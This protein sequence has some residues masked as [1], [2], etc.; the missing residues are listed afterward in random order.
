MSKP[1]SP[2]KIVFPDI[3]GSALEN[4]SIY[5]GTAGLDPVVEV[6]RITVYWDRALTLPASQPIATKGG[7]PVNGGVISRLYTNASDFSMTILDK[8]GASVQTDL[9][10]GLDSSESYTSPGPGAVSR[11]I[12]D[13][14]GDIVAVKDFG[15]VGDG[16]T[17][18][19]TAFQNALIQASGNVLLINEGT[20]NITS[21]LKAENVHIL[22]DKATITGTGSFR[23]VILNDVI[24]Y[25]IFKVPFNISLIGDR[26]DQDTGNLY[27]DP[28]LGDDANDGTLGNPVA[29]LS[30][31][32]VVLDALIALGGNTDINVVVRDGRVEVSSQVNLSASQST[33]KVTIKSNSGETPVFTGPIQWFFRDGSGTATNNGSTDVYSLFCVD[34]E[35]KFVPPTTTGFGDN[36]ALNRNQ[37]LAITEAANVCTLQVDTSV[38]GLINSSSNLTR[39]RL[40]VTQSFTSSI[41]HGISLAGVNMTYTKPASQSQIYYDGFNFGIESGFAPYFIEGLNAASLKTPENWCNNGTTLSLPDY[42]NIFLAPTEL[43][44]PIIVSADRYTFDGIVFKFHQPV[45][46]TV[47]DNYT[48]TPN[49][50]NSML[51]YT[52]ADCFFQNCSIQYVEGAG[53]HSS[54]NNMMILDNK[55]NFWVGHAC[56]FNGLDTNPESVTGCDMLRNEGRYWGVNNAGCRFLHGASAD[57]EIHDNIAF[58]GPTSALFV[59]AD[60]TTSI[61]IQCFRNVFY[62]LGMPEYEPSERFQVADS[63]GYYYNGVN[64][65]CDHQCHQNVVFNVTGYAGTRGYY[66]DNQGID[67][68]YQKNLGFNVAGRVF[69]NRNVSGLTDGNNYEENIFYGT[70]RVE[71]NT[72][73]TFTNN[74]LVGRNGYGE[75]V[76]SGAV[77]VVEPN[78][79]I[80][81][82]GSTNLRFAELRDIETYLNLNIDTP[83]LD[84]VSRYLQP[85]L[86]TWEE[87]SG[88]F[89]PTIEGST[90]AGSPTYDIQIGEYHLIGEYLHFNL[91]VTWSAIGGATGN[92]RVNLNDLPYKKQLLAS[93][94][95]PYSYRS[96]I[97]GL[98]AVYGTSNSKLID[99]EP[100]TDITTVTNNTVSIQGFF[101][102]TA[103]P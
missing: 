1:I 9:N 8:N 24:P 13:K 99:I 56:F 31:L 69:D 97:A 14:L 67:G 2:V 11:P 51:T 54:G 3:D 102:F 86:E 10:A 33:A 93:N 74:I 83:R 90:V 32:K 70:V 38:Q 76:F 18:D 25:E 47:E 40:N 87:F 35:L 5:I 75:S 78:N 58:D 23:G 39:A 17:D 15:A 94:L 63:G 65:T 77:T 89:T 4:G 21:E 62:N 84:P 81:P 41:Y 71:D 91:N 53:L 16:I 29:T 6:N 49:A 98:T 28:C 73:A 79:G 46:A 43:D 26:S 27:L 100:A 72:A 55:E 95:S 88:V 103:T 82:T 66:I 42:G 48:N 59:Q 50:A 36:K 101:K 37:A 68:D 57:L 12:S 60:N 30:R 34:E 45:K 19:T 96:D 85:K 20:Y 80:N 52:G 44:Q 22:Q 92:L 61:T 7:F 64:V